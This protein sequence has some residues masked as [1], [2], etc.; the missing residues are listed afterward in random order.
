MHGVGI[1][2]TIRDDQLQDQLQGGGQ[3]LTVLDI[4]ISENFPE[5]RSI[6]LTRKSYVFCL[7]VVRICLLYCI[8]RRRGTSLIG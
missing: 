6:F 4:K 3:C 8:E 2:A 5:N 7:R 1:G